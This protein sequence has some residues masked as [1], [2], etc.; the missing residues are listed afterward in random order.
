LPSAALDKDYTAKLLSAK[1]ILL[2][3]FCRALGKGFAECHDST[4]QRKVV[5]TARSN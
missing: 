5:V 4:W 3:A 2:S 1:A